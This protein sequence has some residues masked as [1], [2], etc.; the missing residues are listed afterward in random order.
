LLL[1]YRLP[2]EGSSA[3][4]AVWRDEEESALERLQRW[5]ERNQP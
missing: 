1:T 3:R 2:S 4:V 5:Q